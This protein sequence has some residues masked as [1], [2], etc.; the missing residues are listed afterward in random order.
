MSGIYVHPPAEADGNK[1][2]RE[3]LVKRKFDREPSCSL[4]SEVAERN[5]RCK[6]QLFFA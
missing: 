2:R 4:I 3:R 5:N 1:R 6:G